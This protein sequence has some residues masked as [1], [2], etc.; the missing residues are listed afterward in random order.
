[1]EPLLVRMNQLTKSG[2]EEGLIMNDNRLRLRG[3]KIQYAPS[4]VK[5]KNFYRYEGMSDPEDNSILYL[6]ETY[7]GHKAVI[8]DSYGMYADGKVTKFIKAVEEIK[9]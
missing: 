1:M 9:K 5:L 2:F 3:G 6:L 8:M 4:E 7:D